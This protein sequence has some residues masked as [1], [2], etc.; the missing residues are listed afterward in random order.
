MAY[1]QPEADDDDAARVEKALIQVWAIHVEKLVGLK[2]PTHT[3]DGGTIER[4]DVKVCVLRQ[5]PSDY[6]IRLI[7]DLA[8]K[9]RRQMPRDQAPKLPPHDPVVQE[10][11]AR[12]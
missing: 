1:A 6:E 8:W 12:L 9:Y 4:L 7:K 5:M 10:M 11:G 2:L 3:L